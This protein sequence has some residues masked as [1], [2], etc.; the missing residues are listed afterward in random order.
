MTNEAKELGKKIRTELKKAGYSAKDVSV[1]IRES[2]YADTYIKATIKNPNV[3]QRAIEEIL[4]K[5]EDIDRDLGSYEILQGCNTFVIV[6]YEE[7]VFDEVISELIPTAEKVLQDSD[8]WDGR[9]I[10]ENKETE[11]H[12]IDYRGQGLNC[13]KLA[14]LYKDRTKASQPQKKIYNARDLA[15]AMWKYQNLGTVLA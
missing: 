6:Q 3:S 2:G 10:A 1:K 14:E 9:K 12:L 5:Y 4:N 7:N 15:T 8:K 11:V 13:W